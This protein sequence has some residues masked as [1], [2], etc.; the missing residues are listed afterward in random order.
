MGELI[1]EVQLRIE[2]LTLKTIKAKQIKKKCNVIFRPGTKRHSG[3]KCFFEKTVC[4]W[5]VVFLEECEAKVSFWRRSGSRWGRL[6]V[7]LYT[8]D[9]RA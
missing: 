7:A 4:F 3:K 9:R 5:R 6:D 1:K 8:A 2:M